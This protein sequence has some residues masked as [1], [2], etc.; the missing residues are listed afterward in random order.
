[1]PVLR[2]PLRFL[3]PL[4]M[5]GLLVANLLEFGVQQAA[6][7]DAYRPLRARSSDQ[8][9]AARAP[10]GILPYYM[11]QEAL[12]GSEISLSDASQIQG[13]AWRNLALVDLVRGEDRAI[14]LAAVAPLRNRVHYTVDGYS[15]QARLPGPLR[16]RF[17]L[18]PGELRGR[19]ALLLPVAADV[20]RGAK[21]EMFLAPATDRADLEPFLE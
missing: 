5:A 9:T 6:T 4:V 3:F 18:A 15:V 13:W 19:R 14:R 20:P 10:L 16:V 7:Q 1:M 21:R 2:S 8:L 12:R 11:L 17:L